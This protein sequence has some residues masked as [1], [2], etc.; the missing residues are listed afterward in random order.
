MVSSRLRLVKVAGEE[1]FAKEIQLSRDFEE[2]E[3]LEDMR[4]RLP[5]FEASNCRSFK[6]H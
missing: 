4:A 1:L 2:K 6:G 3:L 5:W